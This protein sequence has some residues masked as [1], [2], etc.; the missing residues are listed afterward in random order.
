M[1][2]NQLKIG[3]ILSYIGL[4]INVLVG[5]LYTP[6][7]INSIGK[8]DYGLYTLALSVISVFVFDFGIGQAV[9]RFV[10]K[11]LAE[12]NLKK[13]NNC[14][15]L[16]SKLYIYIDVI[17]FLILTCVYFFI[18]YLY[19]EL[20]PDELEKF[21]NIYIVVSL[22]SV[23]SFPFISVSGILTAAEKFVQLKFCDLCHK[24]FIV[25]MMTSCLL[26]GWGLYALVLVN[27][28][29]GL[30]TIVLKLFFIKKDTKISANFSYEDK[31]ELREIMS[32]SG[33]VM[34]KALA[35]RMIFTLSP[36]IIAMVSGS[37]EVALFGIVNLIEGYVYSFASAISGLFLPKVYRIVSQGEEN[38]MPL[39]IRIGRIIFFIIAYITIGFL[40]VG[41]DFLAAWLGN[42]FENIYWSVIFVILPSI[43]YLPH[44]IGFSAIEALNKVKYQ[45]IVFVFMGLLNVFIGYFLA[46]RYGCLGLCISIFIAYSIRNI[47]IDYILKKH[48]HLDIVCFFKEVFIKPFGSILIV[49]LGGFF[50]NRIPVHGWSGFL[51]KGICV[52]IVYF[53]IMY[54]SILNT[55]ERGLIKSFLKVIYKIKKI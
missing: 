32:F 11:Y 22:F 55:Y 20:T 7:M 4:A 25:V 16:V 19:K 33:W 45:A 34:V 10:A 6:W 38:I 53:L 1:K 54:I 30:L 44:E 48:L 46:E 39:M 12:G 50:I 3:A 5:L 35:G 49:L 18:P 9:T 27:A 47:G 2:V 51:I 13:A 24:L 17:I 37:V 15:G 21:R 8:D 52:T 36:S 42:G 41:Q 28:I 23:I 31:K 43:I 29:A 14:I 40:T 26:M